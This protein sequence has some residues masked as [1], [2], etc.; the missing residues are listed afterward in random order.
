MPMG[1]TRVADQYGHLAEASAHREQLAVA[2]E[3]ARELADAS[4]TFGITPGMNDPRRMHA[5]VTDTP[6]WDGGSPR[7]WAGDWG[8]EDHDAGLPE[9]DILSDLMGVPP[10][11]SAPDLSDSKWGQGGW[12]SGLDRPFGE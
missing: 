10:L 7:D 9:E 8:Q 2:L 5:G 3:G 4:K 12:E 6:A 11:A 1:I